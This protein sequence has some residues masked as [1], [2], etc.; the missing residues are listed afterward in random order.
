MLL[1]SRQTDVTD[2]HDPRVAEILELVAVEG[3]RLRISIDIILWLEDRGFVVDLRTGVAMKVDIASVT[4]SGKAV[5]HL[6]TPVTERDIEQTL[7]S[8]F[9]AE[10]VEECAPD[11]TLQRTID[12]GHD[13]AW[14]EAE[15]QEQIDGRLDDEYHAGGNW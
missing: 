10:N 13:E 1:F 11:G 3:I 14:Y 8:L 5:S 4:A 15:L 7:D 2:A 9:A 6:L 12:A